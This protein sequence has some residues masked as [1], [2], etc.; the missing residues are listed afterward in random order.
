MVILCVMSGAR[1]STRKDKTMRDTTPHHITPHHITRRRPITLG[2]VTA[3]RR[4]TSFSLLVGRFRLHL[5]S[6]VWWNV[7]FLC[8]SH[9]A[10]AAASGGS[11][12]GHGRSIR[13]RCFF[14]LGQG[15]R[16]G[17]RH[18]VPE[19]FFGNGRNL[20]RVWWCWRCRSGLD[21][22]QLGR[23]FL[24]LFGCL[25]L[26]GCLNAGV[27]LEFSVVDSHLLPHVH[28]EIHNVALVLGDGPVFADPDLLRNLAD[29]SHVVAHQNEAALEFVD[30]LGQCVDAL[31]VEMVRRFVQ[32]Q[33]VGDLPAQLG[34]DDPGFLSVGELLHLAN[35]HGAAH[36]E[37]PEVLALL[38]AGVIGIQA[39]KE[40]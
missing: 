35:L 40:L 1:C 19:F 23:L 36:A 18:L 38:V 31:H 4:E 24:L 26:A 30:G 20:C 32:E 3:R 5:F 11:N 10:R 9:G 2:G 16:D 13:L 14:R 37:A 33:D 21:D 6:E 17:R 8:G 27:S 34:E 12:G 29:Q 22:L 15:T 39:L 7:S 25:W 28:L